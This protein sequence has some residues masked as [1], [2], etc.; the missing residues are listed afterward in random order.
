MQPLP[1]P[2][3]YA[4]V[5]R[6]RSRVQRRDTWSREQLLA[7]QEQ[8]LARLLA[9]ARERSAFYADRLPTTDP[10]G[11]PELPVLTK[12]TLMAEWDRICTDPALRLA[13]VEA[14]LLAEERSAANPGRA[15]RGRWWL[16]ATGGTTGRRAALAWNRR[17]WAQ[18]L[19]SYA[20]VNDWAGVELDLRYPVRT[21]VVSSRNPTHQSAAVGASL[22]SPLVPALRLDARTPLP[23]LVERLNE[24]QPR[25]LVA[26]ASMVAPLA[27]EQIAGRLAIRPEKFV[28]ASEVLPAPARALAEQGWG[29]GVVVDS[30]AA[31]ET[32][33]IAST[34]RHGGWHLYEDFVI[35]EPVDDDHQ[36]VPAGTTGSRLLVT[37][38]FTRTL[39]LIRYE[40]TDAVRLATRACPCGLPFALLEAVEGRTEDTLQMAGSAGP[41]RV[42][43]VVFHTALEPY[44]PEGWQ[45]EQQPDGGLLVRVVGDRVEADVIAQRIHAALAQLGVAEPHI[46]VAAVAGIERTALGKAPLVKGRR[47]RA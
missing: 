32:A 44:A 7:Y 30:Y 5:L 33:S 24:F 27:E 45:V 21:A 41:V 4:S 42:H 23:E 8:A 15:W 1:D 17:E 16:A 22:R 20:R 13:D 34:C 37:P 6:V 35:A 2:L 28:A 31:T 11:L 25:L 26:Y 18:V 9:H 29:A 12:Q 38:L 47:P 36:L 46:E 39:P 10:R 14:R 3:L 19:A 40:L 43:P